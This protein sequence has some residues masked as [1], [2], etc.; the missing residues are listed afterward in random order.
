VAPD[1]RFPAFRIPSCNPAL[2]ILCTLRL[3]DPKIWSVEMLASRMTFVQLDLG[4]E[5]QALAWKS[6]QQYWDSM[7]HYTN[8]PHARTNLPY[9]NPRLDY[10]QSL[11]SNKYP[12]LSAQLLE[13]EV[14]P[15][16]YQRTH[17]DAYLANLAEG[18]GLKYP[19]QSLSV[20]DKKQEE[21]KEGVKEEAVKEEV[22]K[23]EMMKEEVVA[24]EARLQTATRGNLDL[25]DV[26]GR[27]V[28]LVKP[29]LGVSL[30]LD[31][32]YIDQ[33]GGFIAGVLSVLFSFYITF[34]LFT[35]QDRDDAAASIA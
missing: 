16:G 32:I 1:K 11:A 26:T 6:N 3:S 35:T 18:M 20:E 33:I 7:F 22:V 30:R 4:E 27:M 8:N 34:I 25:S 28:D 12:L 31:D 19:V 23:E 14:P 17:I 21:K 13:D 10:Y 5:M 2:D 9:P 15:G 24:E 29:V